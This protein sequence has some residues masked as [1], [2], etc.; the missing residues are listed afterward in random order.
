[1]MTQTMSLMILQVVICDHKIFKSGQLTGLFTGITHIGL[2]NHPL[3]TPET[4]DLT[5]NDILL[6]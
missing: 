4:T 1:M 6:S 2:S 3:T 5:P